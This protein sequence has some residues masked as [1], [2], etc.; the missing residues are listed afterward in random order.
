[1]LLRLHEPSAGAIHIDGEDI[2]DASLASLRAAV[3]V[4]P[5]DAQLFDDTLGYNIRY[6]RPAMSDVEM[7]EAARHA[8]LAGFIENL[9]LGYDTRIGER[10]QRLS[11]RRAP[12]GDKRLAPPLSARL[13][14]R[15]GDLL[16]RHYH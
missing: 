15:R 10:G 1:M 12:A 6:G 9:P 3:G 7:H 2:R 8:Q 16:T 14:V 13:P 5:Q 4:V 11:R